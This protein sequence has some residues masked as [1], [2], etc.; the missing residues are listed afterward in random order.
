MDGTCRTA[1]AAEALLRMALPP[2]HH[3]VAAGCRRDRARASD[4]LHRLRDVPQ[5]DPGR[6]LHDRGVR[7]PD[8]PLPR[9]RAPTAPTELSEA[10]LTALEGRTC[11]LLANHGM[12]AT[13]RRSRQGDVAR[14]RAGDALPAIRRRPQVGGPQILSDEEIAAHRS[15]TAAFK[16]SG[17][18]TGCKTRPRLR[19]ADASG[20]DGV[21]MTARK[22]SSEHRTISSS[23]AAA[24][25]APA[26][27]ATPPAAAC[28]AARREGRPRARAPRPAPASWST[29]ACATS[30]ITSSGSC[31]RR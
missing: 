22:S 24:S 21:A 14:G 18:P 1:T 28:G 27:R 11:C 10:A 5:G 16:V 2:R 4:L 7:R 12:I 31:A 19:P 9:L 3:E 6:A 8:D 25:T 15:R 26:S 20:P 29:A 13:G 23:S 30:S 17:Q